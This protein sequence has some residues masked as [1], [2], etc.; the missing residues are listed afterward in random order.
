M[1]ELCCRVEGRH[2]T[3]PTELTVLSHLLMTDSSHSDTLPH[4]WRER[5]RFGK[6][7]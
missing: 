3:V 1:P 4:L 5:E 2:E 6:G 7:D